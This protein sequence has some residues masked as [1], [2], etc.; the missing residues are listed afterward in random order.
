MTVV[1]GTS[2]ADALL[3]T[4]GNDQL[5]GLE[6]DD[7]L[8]GSAGSDVLDGGEG[9]DTADYRMLTSG[10]SV[11]IGKD[12]SMV[13]GGDG[14]RDTLLNVE[15]VIGTWHNDTF[16][17]DVAGVTLDGSD[18]DDVYIVNS[19]DVSIIEESYGGYDELRTSL[20][21]IKMGA[22]VEKLTFTGTGDFHA[23]GSDTDNEIIAG[24][25]NDWLW[26]G[27]GADHF[28]GGDGYDT[29][30]YS[31]SLEGVRVN[32]NSNFDGLTIAYGDTFTG[33]EAIEGSGFDDLIY[34]NQPADQ[35]M[36]I[37]GA[38][39]YDTVS[40]QNSFDS[41]TVDVGA[42]SSLLNVEKVI[43]S[44]G[45]DHFT[46]NS[47]GLTLAGGM[48]DDVY[49]IN[50]AGVTLEEIEG[51]MGG[52]DQVYTSLSEMRLGA[53]VENLTYTGTGDF[54]GHGN[55]ESNI[56]VS[57]AGNDVL[58]GGA[59]WDVLNGGAGID[60]VS[61]ADSKEGLTATLNWG[62]RSGDALYHTYIDI[63]GLRGSQFGDQLYGDSGDNILEG[64]A[65]F[66]MIYGGEGNDHIYGGL[67]SG[68]D[69]QGYNADW[70]SG[71]A[72]DDV[73]VSDAFDATS[74]AS[75]D[76]GND[77]ITMVGGQA[78]GGE[79]ND[80]LTGT[81]HNFM[82][83]GD[84]GNDLLILNLAGQ[85]TSGGSAYG[86]QGDDTYVVNTS[87]LVTIQ[88]EG[89]DLNDTL[90]LNTIANAS[91]LNVSRIG[92]DAY[93]HSA[94]DGTSDVPNNGVKLA[95]WYAGF[96]NIE[97]IQTADGQVYD[98]PTSGDAFAMFG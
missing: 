12:S 21:T 89:W 54:I 90:I 66:D 83:F 67:A 56:I 29:V 53:Y 14:K 98:L 45:A 95:G 4:E 81:G 80:I 75:G 16:S 68:L 55:D 60:I 77:T 58:S 6:A 44:S 94:N 23:Y 1:N 87:G 63:E 61:Y 73:I 26:G 18:G 47:G 37:D 27:D 74:S 5:Y 91:Q 7:L 25:G 19:A 51:Y 49:T 78:R 33:I 40:Y 64:G 28:V 15:K 71:G 76:E 11:E 41:V 9:F 96:N 39:G 48:G 34:L 72:G 8:Y 92:N 24:A 82:L 31:D 79:G 20:N 2:E 84:E 85:S 88:D 42:G 46:A 69:T 50:S 52:T 93:L 35:A 97:H 57:G 3:G 86:G 13:A 10:V 32:D 30:S 62:P 38:G 65:G 59:G 43:G 22:W 36:I 17:S 70:L